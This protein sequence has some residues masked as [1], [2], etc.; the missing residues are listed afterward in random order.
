MIGG[1][2]DLTA[3]RGRTKRVPMAQLMNFPPFTAVWIDEFKQ[4][5]AADSRQFSGTRDAGPNERAKRISHRS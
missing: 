5:H 2:D 4:P 1:T 3:Q